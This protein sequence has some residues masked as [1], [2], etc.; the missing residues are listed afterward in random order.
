VQQ[1]PDAVADTALI[2]EITP[3]NTHDRG[4]SDGVSEFQ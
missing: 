2:P 4:I 1:H 3:W